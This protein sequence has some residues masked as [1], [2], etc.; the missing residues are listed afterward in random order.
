MSKENDRFLIVVVD[1]NIDNL[2]V[3][4]IDIRALAGTNYCRAI[5]ATDKGILF[6]KS[7]ADAIVMLLEEYTDLKYKLEKVEFETI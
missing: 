6:K 5:Y 3:A 2:Y 1:D 7:V 4:R